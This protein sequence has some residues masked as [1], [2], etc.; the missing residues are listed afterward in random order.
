MD[1][2]NFPLISYIAKKKIPIILSTGFGNFREIKKSIDII[3]KNKCKLIIL[4]CVSEYPPNDKDL[5]LKRILKYKKL[6]K[7]PVGFSD[8]TVGTDITFAAMAIGASI[9]EKHFTINK[10]MKGWDHSIS[11][12]PEDLKN[13][14]NY[15]K[16]LQKVLGKENIYRVESDLKTMKFRRSIVAKRNIQKWE[17]IKFKDL[18]YKRP[19]N[20]IPP[21]DWKKIVGKYPKKKIFYDEQI[22]LK[23]LKRS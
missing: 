22:N 8:H 7:V 4:H 14:N 13:I 2:N 10:K 17:K 9:V 20:G 19:G 15:S 18:S 23:N 21:G 5:N 11:A 16:K 12:D 6:F 3:K 1:I